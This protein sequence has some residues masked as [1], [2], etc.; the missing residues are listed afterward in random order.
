MLT[1]DLTEVIFPACGETRFEKANQY[2]IRTSVLKLL[3]KTRC[4]KVSELSFRYELAAMNTG[5]VKIPKTH[6]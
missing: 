6:K 4:L 5:G 1:V 3:S 2:S